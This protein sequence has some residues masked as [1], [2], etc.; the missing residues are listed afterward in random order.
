VIRKP[1]LTDLLII[2]LLLNTLFSAA[3][4]AE[5]KTEKDLSNQL[6]LIESWM[7]GQRAYDRIPALSAA[8]VHDQEL[9]W[10]G[11]SGYADVESEEPARA[12]TIYGICSISKLFTGIAVMQLRDQGKVRLEDPV[13]GLLPWFNIERVHDGSPEITLEGMLTHSAGLPRESEAPYWMGPD[14]PFPTQSEIRQK[15][16]SQSTLYPSSLY[17]QYSNLGLTLV[18]EVVEERS[19]QPFEAYIRDHLLEPMGLSDTDTGFPEDAREPRIA[20]GYSFPG[21]DGKIL[22]APRYDARGITPAAGFA[23][24]ALDLAKFASWQFRVR[25]GSDD[26]VLASNTLK[27]MQR[28][29]WMDWDWGTSW[30]L[31]F[32]IYRI[33]DRTLTGHGGSCPGFNTRLYIDPVSLYG[34]AVMANRNSANVNNYARIMLDI[35]EADGSAD[36]SKESGGPDLADYVGSY[37]VRPWNGEDMVF[38]WKDALAVISLPTMD[39]LGDMQLLKHHEG[40]VFHAVR[41]DEQPGHEVSFLRDESGQ[42]SHL[43]YHSNPVPKMKP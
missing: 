6:A 18:G 24:T 14:F 13:S 30:G 5:E 36:E 33:G 3:S 20:T 21:R 38:Q 42:V 27:E 8:L 35:L 1:T 41:S 4:A 11:A 40:D 23:S 19:G 37:D 16:G 12:D 29:H 10:S 17:F 39:P 26:P 32:G 15:L 25:A 22:P 9:L 34:V 7:D 31:A 2:I 28:V 43:V